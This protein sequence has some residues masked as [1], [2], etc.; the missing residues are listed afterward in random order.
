MS[1]ISEIIALAPLGQIF[2]VCID[3]L[4]ANSIGIVI[5]HTDH[6]CRR[7]SLTE[8]MD[9]GQVVGCGVSKR[10]QEGRAS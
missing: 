9:S 3:V 2:C 10:L 4:S 8:E 1:Q 7:M 6:T 5:I